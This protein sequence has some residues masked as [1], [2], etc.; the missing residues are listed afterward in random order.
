MNVKTSC[1]VADDAVKN[2]PDGCKMLGPK[3]TVAPLTDLSN[4]LVV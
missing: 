4:K 3:D 2:E 1:A